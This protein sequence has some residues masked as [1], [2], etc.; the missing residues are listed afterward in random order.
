ME[1][2]A[3]LAQIELLNGNEQKAVAYVNEILTHLETGNLDGVNFPLRVHLICYKVLKELDDI[4]SE[5]LLEIALSKLKRWSAAIED[6]QL[7]QS[8][9]SIAKVQIRINGG[10]I[11]NAL[12]GR[13]N[14]V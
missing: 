3:D 7:R 4:R 12:V 11:Y 1:P 10:S 2:L 14:S 5:Q 8:Y 13:A 9:L 6:E